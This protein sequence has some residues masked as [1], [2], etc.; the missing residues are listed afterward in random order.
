[1]KMGVL[2][3]NLGTPHSFRPKDVKKYLTEF[4]TDRR[5]IDLPFLKRQLL[6]RGVIVPKR[7]KASAKLYAS[8]WTK[9]GSPLLYY[10]QQLAE[11][12]QEKLGEEYLVQLAMRYQTPSIEEGLRAL[13]TCRK[14]IIFPLFPQYASATTGS[15]HEKVM[16]LLSKW[17]VIP[18]VHFLSNYAAHPAFIAAH[19]LRAKEYDLSRYD[20]IL[21]SYHGLP[22]KQLK[23]SDPTGTCLIN[24]ECCKKNPH[25]YAAQCLQTT[26]KI[27]EGL[28]L[29]REKWTL[30]Y[31]SRLGKSPW[32][33]PYSDEVL[34]TLAKEG[35]KRVL[36][37]SPAFVADC[38]E[39]LEE[40]A[41]GYRS[42]FLSHGG[43]TLDLAEGLNDHPAWI[44]AIQKIIYQKK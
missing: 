9:Q 13:K 7:V 14:L 29:P 36:V 23:K 41:S 11:K 8:I 3:V 35:K 38:L 32:I 24:K 25:C 4:L 16:S 31:Q 28:N 33:R 12:L 43:E 5:V 26:Q 19:L 37:F 27:A 2:L 30:S 42:L 17:E 20:H 21:F 6:V 44:D 22:E 10:G 34:K 39:T 18:E 15:V 40:I 1:M